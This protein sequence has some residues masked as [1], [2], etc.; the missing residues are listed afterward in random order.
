MRI[1]ERRV[2]YECTLLVDRRLPHSSEIEKHE[3]KIT[4]DGRN[5]GVDLERKLKLGSRRLQIAPSIGQEPS[6]EVSAGQVCRLLARTEIFHAFRVG[7]PAE[8]R[9]CRGKLAVSGKLV[10]SLRDGLLEMERGLAFVAKPAVRDS[11]PVIDACA[12]VAAGNCVEFSKS[13][14]EPALLDERGT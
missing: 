13:F 6:I 10:R 7:D 12:R 11:C 4:F 2:D 8:A 3:C 9:V 1:C 14:P 5:T